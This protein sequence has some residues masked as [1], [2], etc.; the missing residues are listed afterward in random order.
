MFKAELKERWGM[1]CDTDKLVADM[2][3]LLTKYHHDCT[4]HGVC[5]ILDTYF[6]N[7]KD[8]IDMFQTSENYIGNMRICVD[9]E[10]ERNTSAE[11]IRY[12]CEIF[13]NSVGAKDVFYKYVDENGKTL[14]D[15]SRVGVKKFKARLLCYGNLGTALVDNARYRSNFMSNG[16]TVKSSNEYDEFW[17]MIYGFRHS[18]GAR[19]SSATVDVLTQ[20]KINGRFTVGMK[21]SRAFNRVCNIY[22]VDKLPAYNKMFAEYAD[23]VSDL[24]RKLKFYISVNPLDY[25]TMS[26]G[27][28]WSSCHTIDKNNERGMP[29][30]YSGM[31]CGGT[32]SYMLDGTSIITYVH[33]HA[34]EDHEEGKLYRN[35]FHFDNGTL[36][37]GRVYPQAN[38]G[39]T[40]LYKTFRRFVQIEF[41]KL[42]NLNEDDW[43]RRSVSCCENVVSYGVHYRD[44]EHFS[45]CNTSYPREMP[46]A[47]SNVVVVGHSRI[48]PWCGY[49]VSDSEDGGY[50]NH[51]DCDAVENDDEW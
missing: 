23:M 30:S 22:G 35:M 9:V 38:D 2:M 28:S 1:Y 33:T 44:Y 26:F 16:V 19:L 27:K 12:F 47:A 8:L 3:M 25:L 24:K 42:L 29:N 51:A 36:I 32:M 4:E 6:T 41:T 7:K 34:T 20:Y 10:M 40:D 18:H 46:N 50:L 13:P 31:H 43:I 39:A 15:Y 48:C 37:Q 45:G 49:E 21:T 5:K 17:S 11:D 14:Q